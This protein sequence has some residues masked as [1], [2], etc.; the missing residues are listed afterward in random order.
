MRQS[1][2]AGA[3]AGARVGVA[4]AADA[5][6]GATGDVA[7][8]HQRRD[9]AD[10]VGHGRAAAGRRDENKDGKEPGFHGPRAEGAL[11]SGTRNDESPF[12]GH[13]ASQW[14]SCSRNSPR[15]TCHAAKAVNFT[16]TDANG[17]GSSTRGGAFVSRM[18]PC[19]A[20]PSRS[21]TVPVTCASAA[22]VACSR[23]CAMRSEATRGASAG[24]PKG[25]RGPGP[26]HVMD[27][28]EQ[29]RLRAGRACGP[30][31][32]PSRRRTPGRSRRPRCP[33]A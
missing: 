21:P 1:F 25:I 13:S 24:W 27:P 3:A 26:A 22:G 14:G 9:V 31:C 2:G 8:A 19:S 16:H 5:H 6:R 12:P 29:T 11:I 33:R 23:S 18:N 30:G 32:S 7:G 15:P 28:D 20:C 4:V 17:V 10:A